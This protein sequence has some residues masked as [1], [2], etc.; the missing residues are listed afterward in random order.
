VRE[1]GIVDE[2]NEYQKG[3]GGY[4]EKENLLGREKLTRAEAG[5]AARMVR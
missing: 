5:R 1:E 4:L 2:L 3:K